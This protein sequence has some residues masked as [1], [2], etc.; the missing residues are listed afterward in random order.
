MLDPPHQAHHFLLHHHRL[1]SLIL[2]ASRKARIY[3]QE[4]ETGGSSG[5]SR[6]DLQAA[7]VNLHNEEDCARMYEQVE[8]PE[9][10]NFVFCLQRP[11]PSIAVDVNYRE[12]AWN[13]ILV[14]KVHVDAPRWINIWQLNAQRN[15][16]RALAKFYSFS[17]LLMENLLATESRPSP[18]YKPPKTNKA[19]FG[20]SPLLRSSKLAHDKEDI[21]LG[22]YSELT[23]IAFRDSYLQFRGR[24]SFP[25]TGADSLHYTWMTVDQRYICIAYNR[26]YSDVARP[27]NLGDSSG[28]LKKGEDLDR[29]RSWLIL[30]DDGTIISIHERFLSSDPNLYGSEQKTLRYLKLHTLTVLDRLLTSQG[31]KEKGSFRVS[32]RC[33]LTVLAGFHVADAT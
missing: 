28:C 7:F 12:E 24:R 31:S 14:N 18:R 33:V 29:V 15:A 11:N 13:N 10:Y 16:V 30:C 4:N 1:D 23:D 9:T 2:V 6:S 26:S 32:E 3:Y 5:F 17:P 22:K 20:K 19:A 25:E 8:R 27:R 21:E